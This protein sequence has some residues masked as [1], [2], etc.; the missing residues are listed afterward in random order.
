AALGLRLYKVG[1]V[2]PLE[3]DGAAQFCEGLDK[4]LVVEEKR[5]LLEQQLK[6]QLY[7]R[8]GAPRIVGKLDEHGQV[9]FQSEMA[10]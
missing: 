2:W 6:E 10:L 8:P 7:G 5:S 3:P 1:M 4:V 9:L